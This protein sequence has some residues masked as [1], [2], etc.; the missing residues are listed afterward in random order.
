[1]EADR[2]RPC[3]NG[4]ICQ[5]NVSTT[6]EHGVVLAKPEAR[7]GAWNRSPYSL[8]KEPNPLDILISDF[9]APE[10]QGN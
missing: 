8:Q 7:R 5:H 9:Q 2:E 1:M 10:L 4:T 6:I 3:D